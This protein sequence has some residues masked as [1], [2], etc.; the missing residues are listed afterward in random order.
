MEVRLED[1][2][3][4]LDRRV[5][6]K[7]VLIQ[8]AL[9]DGWTVKKTGENTSTYVFTKKHEGRRECFTD[10][11]LTDFMRNNLDICRVLEKK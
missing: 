2:V 8:N 10:E 6:H 3:V 5:F 9:D 1:R 7:M 4:H 11:Y